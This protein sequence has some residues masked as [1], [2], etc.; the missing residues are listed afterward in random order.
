MCSS[1]SDVRPNI[2]SHTFSSDGISNN[3]E[4]RNMRESVSLTTVTA[5]DDFKTKLKDIRITNLTP[6]VISHININSIRNIFELLAEAV[7]GNVDFLM[8]TETKID[9]SFPTSQFIVLVSLHHI[10]LAELKREEGYLFIKG[11]ILRG[12]L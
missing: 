9:K 3:S 5:K 8:V 7:K 2:E 6:I 1:S 11:K 12:R 10:V 4:T